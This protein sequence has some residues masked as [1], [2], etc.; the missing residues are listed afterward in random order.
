LGLAPLVTHWL[1]FRMHQQG[2]LQLPG[3]Q[4]VARLA[5]FVVAASF[6]LTALVAL[7][8]FIDRGR[9]VAVSGMVGVLI[10]FAWAFSGWVGI[11]Y[12]VHAR[13]R[14]DALQF[15]LNAIAREAQMQALRAQLN[16]HFLFNC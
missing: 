9:P 15:E 6:G 12:A 8:I 14:R 3:W 10:G 5:A 13:R 7:G 2:W 11:Y 16:P 1:R 4:L